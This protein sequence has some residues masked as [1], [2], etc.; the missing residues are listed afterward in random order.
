[1]VCKG[2]QPG[3]KVGREI[4]IGVFN[5]PGIPIDIQCRQTR[6]AGGRVA[7]VGQAVGELAATAQQHLGH[8]V[9]DHAATQGH[10]AVGDRLGEGDQV[11]L[12][13]IG[14]AAKPAAGAAEAADDLVGDEQDIP[15]F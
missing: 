14:L 10:V 4:G 15:F 9:V 3:G 12:H 11:R 13:A 8:L 2:R 7:R 1:M 6:G 5:N